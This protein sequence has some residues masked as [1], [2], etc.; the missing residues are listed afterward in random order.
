MNPIVINGQTYD[1]TE[2]NDLYA[3]YNLFAKNYEHFNSSL[4]EVAVSILKAIEA[5]EKEYKPTFLLSKREIVFLGL[6]CGLL[7]G[8]ASILT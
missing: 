7:G 6:T 2:S 3:A 4:S 8:I 5:R 1:L